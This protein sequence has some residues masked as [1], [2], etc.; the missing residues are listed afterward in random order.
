MFESKAKVYSSA[1]KVMKN[2]I[3]KAIVA[4]LIL[5]SGA[6]AQQPPKSRI[7]KR[8]ALSKAVPC[9]ILTGAVQPKNFDTYVFRAAKNRIIVAHPFYYGRETNR[10]ADDEGVSGF[11]FVS[12]DG[13]AMPDPQDV[14]FKATRAGEYKILVRPAYRRTTGKYV[15]KISV[16]D[17][18]PALYD[19]FPNPPACR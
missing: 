13:K 8:V 15:L 7:T 11:V 1:S 5:I 6:A 9:V 3:L 18:L 12:P 2:N 4:G 14:M 10:R 17:K 19:D 16:T